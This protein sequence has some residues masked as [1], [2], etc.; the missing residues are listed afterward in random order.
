[1]TEGVARGKL[2][3]D[4]TTMAILERFQE[5]L[6]TGE[7]LFRLGDFGSCELIDG[8]VVPMSPTGHLHARLEARL[9]GVFLDYAEQS[10][11]WEVL[12]GEVGIYVRRNPDTIRAADLAL[13]SKERYRSCQS[14]SYL[15]VAPEVI[16]EILSPD[17][18]WLGVMEKLSD[19]FAAGVE[20]VY[21]LDPRKRQIFAYRSITSLV[22]LEEGEVL[23]DPE[24]LP[25]FRLALADL[26]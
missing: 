22:L 26:F 5:P 19:Y 16:V 6:L 15:D 10:G 14:P 3:R 23:E 18:R 25:G 11:E 9:S 24:L 7:E 4:R 12:T 13:I 17:D 2:G 21:V 1:V 8:R 20:R